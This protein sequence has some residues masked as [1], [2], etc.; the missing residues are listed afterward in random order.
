MIDVETYAAAIAYSGKGGGG[1]Q[2][3]ANWK[4][5]TTTPLDEGSTTNPIVIGGETVMA[6]EG[7]LVAYD[8]VEFIFNG[9][10]WQKFGG[11]IRDLID[12]NSTNPQTGE[13]LE[14]NSTTSKYVN[15]RKRTILTAV[16]LAGETT[17]TVTNTAITNTA[18]IAVF[19]ENT[20]MQMEDLSVNGTTVT[21]TFPEQESDVNIKIVITE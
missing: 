5:N 14:Y 11:R 18:M 9:T 19:A 13:V 12:V 21:I 3:Y 10:S 4:G 1:G 15:G 8:G 20:Y 7:W 6:S 2:S 17:V 16:L